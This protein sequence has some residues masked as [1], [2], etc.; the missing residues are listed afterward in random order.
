MLQ[1]AGIGKYGVSKYSDF[2]FKR[3]ITTG[4]KNPLLNIPNNHSNILIR[5]L[6]NNYICT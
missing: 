2:T 5:L 4:E 1:I 3:S 6:Q